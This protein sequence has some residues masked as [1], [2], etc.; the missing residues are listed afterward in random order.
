MQKVKLGDIASVITKGTTPLTVGYDF[1]NKGINFI[2]IE[3]ISENGSFIDKRIAH[4]SEECYKKLS[5]SQLEENDILFSIAGAIGRV[6][7][8]TKNYLPAN[9]NQALAIIRI[10]SNYINY[11]YLFYA[12]QSDSVKNQINGYKQGVAQLNLSLKNISDLVIILH[13]EQKAIAEKLDKVSRLIEKRKQQLSLLDTLVKSKFV[14]M[15]G[16]IGKDEK[17]WG[18]ISLGDICFFNPKKS[19]NLLLKNELEVSFVP[20]TA[21]SEKGEIDGTDVKTYEQVQK[22]FTY[23]VEN[24]VLFAKITPC[25]ENGKGAVACGLKNG[26][27]FGSTEF[28]VMRPKNGICNPTWL[29][30]VTSFKEFR[31]EA[32]RNMTGSAGQRRVP[33]SFLSNYKISLPPLDLQNQ[34]ANFVK[35]TEKTK[36]KIKQSLAALEFLKKSLM[37]K[38]FG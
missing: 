25:M 15:F 6:A 27:G 30:T 38:Y 33:V 18:I 3:A 37:Q 23:F 12:L 26:I 5:R 7:I 32:A 35:Q 19:E 31:Q 34:F 24:D 28:H 13:E 9:T 2:K 21:V 16:M 10:P 22:G 17:G 20:M 1:I 11:R 29:Y 8:V 36:A 14:E 4:I